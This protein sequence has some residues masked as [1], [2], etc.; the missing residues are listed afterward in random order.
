[1]RKH[2][3][4]ICP[5]CGDSLGANQSLSDNPDYECVL[6]GG[7]VDCHTHVIAFIPTKKYANQCNREIHAQIVKERTHD[8]S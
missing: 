7:C 5:D 3:E 8:Y 2:I 1:M 4:I 6:E